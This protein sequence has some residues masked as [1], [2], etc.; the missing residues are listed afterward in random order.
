MTIEEFGVIAEITGA[1]ATVITLLYLAVQVREN[2]RITRSQSAQSSQSRNDLYAT[3]LAEN[4]Q[5]ADVFHRGLIDFNSLNDG[6]RIQLTFLFSMIVGVVEGEF[7]EVR[8][9]I[10]DASHLERSMGGIVGLMKTPGGLHYWETFGEAGGYDSGF[11]AFV[12]KHL[13]GKT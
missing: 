13:S 1:V 9:G 5:L 11:R 6:E 12:D 4:P 10:G 7:D 2:T 8:R 3:A